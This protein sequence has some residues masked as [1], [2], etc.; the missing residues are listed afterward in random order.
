MKKRY[1]ILTLFVFLMGCQLQQVKEQENVTL[2][3]LTFNEQTFRQTYGNFFI[4]THPNYT[5]EVISILES[6]KANTD[7]TKTIEELIIKESPD[8]IAVTMES[9]S[10][11]SDKGKLSSLEDHIKKDKFDL[12]T[13]SP[14]VID[15]LR[16]EQ[17]QLRGLAS[18]FV[19][20][21]LY[22]NKQLFD[23]NGMTYPNDNITWNEVFEIAQQFPNARDQENKQVGLYYKNQ[24]TP[25]MMALTIGEGSGL[26]LYNKDKLTFT[27]SSPSWE[28]VFDNVTNCFKNQACY[29]E[30][31]I[32]KNGSKEISEME[33]G[34]YPFLAGNIAMAIDESTLYQTLV[35]YKDTKDHFDWGIASFPVSSENPDMG[36]GI[37]LNDIFA[38]PANSQKVGRA[39][40]FIKYVSGNNYA[41]ILPQINTYELPARMN[42]EMQDKE[43][44]AFYNVKRINNKLIN[45]FRELPLPLISKLDEISPQYMSDI[46]AEKLSVQESL[47]LMED[48]LHATLNQITDK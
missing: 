10:V 15:Y 48:E 38:I 12:T 44:A 45:Q 27:L 28:K 19:G 40:E 20:K 17:D 43:L 36:N 5:L 21:A 4:A 1:L 24:Y 7:I 33:R 18:T 6:L 13:Y 29:D 46:I 47:K 9:Y 3:V 11:L 34:N 37:Y 31:Q 2:K 22:Y 14:A 23:Q 39:W 42:P 30:S 8:V 32:V 16:D 25:F 41:K 35:K 26:S